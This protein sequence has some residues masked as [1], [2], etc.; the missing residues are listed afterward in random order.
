MKQ[1]FA[2]LDAVAEAMPLYPLDA[3]FERSLPAE[4][5][6]HYETWKARKPG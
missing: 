3:A 2:L 6:S 1:G 5:L 4:L